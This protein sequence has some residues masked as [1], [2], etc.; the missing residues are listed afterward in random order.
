MPT[1]KK[2]ASPTKSLRTVDRLAR[3]GLSTDMALVLHLPLRYEDETRIYSLHEAG[4][5]QEV[6]QKLFG[7]TGLVIVKFVGVATKHHAHH[8]E[9]LRLVQAGIAKKPR[10]HR[11]VGHADLYQATG[12]E[13]A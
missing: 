1:P 5:L 9:A 3:L 13:C 8:M 10:Q 6:C 7:Q 12:F 11:Q 2:K 4:L